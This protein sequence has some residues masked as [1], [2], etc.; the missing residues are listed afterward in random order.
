M[1]RQAAILSALAFF[2]CFPIAVADEPDPVETAREA[3]GSRPSMPWYN[4]ADDT[5]ARIEIDSSGE[6]TQRASDWNRQEELKD[7]QSSTKRRRGTSEL[8]GL[9]LRILAWSLLAVVL[10][11]VVLFIASAALR[12][13]GGDTDSPNVVRKGHADRVENLPFSVPSREGDFLSA[14]RRCYEAGDFNNAITYLFSYQLVELDHSHLIRLSRGKTNRQYLR[15]LRSVPELR[16]IMTKTVWA[17]EEVFFG[18]HSLTRRQF[19]E[20]WRQIDRF[21][22][23][24]RQDTA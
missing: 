12:M 20:C 2:W 23:L 4:E 5:V 10:T 15:E 8:V 1:T 14:A 16:R 17:F 3:L 11:A 24:V 9:I 21:H 18:H 13:D 7:D 6:A 19:D 22:E